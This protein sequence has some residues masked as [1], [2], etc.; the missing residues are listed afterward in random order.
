MA[1]VSVIRTYQRLGSFRLVERRVLEASL[2][3]AIL[4]LQIW[5]R[6]LA[7]S[8]VPWAVAWH[9]ALK[10]QNKMSLQLVIVL[11]NLQVGQVLQWHPSSTLDTS[12]PGFW[13]TTVLLAPGSR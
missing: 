3:F 12:F 13:C 5:L 8:R 1:V 2:P 11:G 4:S 6:R 9:P 7:T 10:I